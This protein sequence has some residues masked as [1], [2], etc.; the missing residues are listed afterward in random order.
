MLSNVETG[1]LEKVPLKVGTVPVYVNPL[2]TG[3]RLAVA[4]NADRCRNT[5]PGEG[6]SEGDWC[7][8]CV[9][10]CESTELEVW[11]PMLTNAHLTSYLDVWW[12]MWALTPQPQIFPSLFRPQGV[13]SQPPYRKTVRAIIFTL[14]CLAHCRPP[15][16]DKHVGLK[17]HMLVAWWAFYRVLE[18]L[19]MAFISP[20]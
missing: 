11:P 18:S 4:P 1:H 12:L 3:N 13:Q 16:D 10:W 20:N 8:H 17:K 5:T 14:A 7:G 2:K 6:S 9:S 15:W 19:Q